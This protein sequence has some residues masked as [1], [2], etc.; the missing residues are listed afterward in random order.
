[1]ALRDTR[2]N[3]YDPLP[4][5]NPPSSSGDPK[6]ILVVDDEKPLRDILQLTLRCEGF[7]VM[8]A[9]N[10]N[11]AMELVRTMPFD[12]VVTD[13][14]MPGKDGIETIIELRALNRE[15]KII[16]MSGGQAGGTVDFLPL[17]TTLGVSAVLKKPFESEQFINTLRAVLEQD[18]RQLTA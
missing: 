8:T 11:E 12:L 18:P 16:A 15:L 4:P 5:M 6:R 17:A 9:A 3:R 2:T 10:G 13:I 7:E 1:M 14:M